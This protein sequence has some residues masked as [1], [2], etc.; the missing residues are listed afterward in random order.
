MNGGEV[1]GLWSQEGSTGGREVNQIATCGEEAN[2]IILFY[3]KHSLNTHTHTQC[4]VA[5][6]AGTQDTTARQGGKGSSSSVAWKD[7]TEVRR[8]A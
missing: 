4:G 6:E 7:I 5:M 2:M 3:H 8:H 1:R